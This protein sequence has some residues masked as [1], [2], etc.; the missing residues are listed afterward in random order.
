MCSLVNIDLLFSEERYKTLF[1]S[2]LVAP[3]ESVQEILISTGT[4]GAVLTDS[5]EQRGALEAAQSPELLRPEG[6]EC[7]SW[8]VDLLWSG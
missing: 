6:P 5:W 2:F 7:G 3:E 8:R 1:S 4:A